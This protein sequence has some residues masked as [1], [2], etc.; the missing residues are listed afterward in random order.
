MEINNNLSSLNIYSKLSVKYSEL[1]K[2]EE[3]ELKSI[4]EKS[5]SIIE[6]GINNY[7]ENDYKR[8]LEKFKNIDSKTKAH[9]QNHAAKGDALS[10]NYLYQMG[11][12]GK[13]YATGGSVRFDTS[14][15][16]DKEGA[17]YK[18]EKLKNASNGDDMSGADLQIA[19]EA[20]LNKML[21]SLSKGENNEN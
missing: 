11:P 4:Y 13:M 9:E 17:L 20:N 19:R 18:L 7:D 12:D 3:K 8:V 1:Q 14:I 21:L 10:I 16:K 2:A 5:D 6:L 15:P